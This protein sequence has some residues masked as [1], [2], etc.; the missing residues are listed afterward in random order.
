[1]AAAEVI[2]PIV[3]GLVRPRS[4]VDVGCGTG[5][6]LLAFEKQGVTDSLGLDREEVGRAFRLSGDRFRPAD[7]SRPLNVGR[8]FDLAVSLEVAEHLPESA[9]ESFV[10]SLTRLSPLVLFSAAIPGQGGKNHVNEQWRDYW[11][12]LFAS[13]G[14]Q[15]LDPIRGRVW[16]DDRVAAFYAQNLMLFARETLLEARPEL[17]A[18]RVGVL[19]PGQSAVH[20]RLFEARRERAARLLAKSAERVAKLE[21]RRGRYEDL[22]PASA[23]RLLP[24]L[25]WRSIR[26]RLRGNRPDS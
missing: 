4:V 8:E 13:R 5:S 14:Y 18:E 2:V 16:D 6:W 23:L 21:D 12:R 19:A 17:A 1:M 26:R 20:P 3:V 15:A 10:G 9:A 22:S 25:L 7:L 11:V 24:G